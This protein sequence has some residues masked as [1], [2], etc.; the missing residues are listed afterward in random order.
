[1]QLFNRHLADFL[2]TLI[3]IINCNS[4]KIYFFYKHDENNMADD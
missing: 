1:L 4:Y 2:L 3:D